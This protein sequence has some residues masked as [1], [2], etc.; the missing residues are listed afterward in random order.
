MDQR[1]G[2]WPRHITLG[3]PIPV[4]IIGWIL[5]NFGHHI[6]GMDKTNVDEI[7]MA[8]SM[9]NHLDEPLIVNVDEGEHGERVQVY[10]G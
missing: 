9:T 10:I 7:L 1:K 5:R 8:L 4:G 2:E 6:R 3:F